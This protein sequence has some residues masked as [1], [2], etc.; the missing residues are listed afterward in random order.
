MVNFINTAPVYLP[1]LE[2]GGHPGWEVVEGTPTELNDLLRSGSL[3]AGL[4]S[5]F[6]YGVDHDDYV[7]L[8]DLGISACG[9]VGSVLL[10]SRMEIDTLDGHVVGLTPQ[11]ATSVNLLRIIFEKF[12]GVRPRYRSGCFMELEQGDA[13][14]YLSIGDEA[15]RR[16]A[17]ASGY[18][19]YDLASIWLEHTGLPFVFAVCAVRDDV[20]RGNPDGVR[21]LGRKLSEC[22]YRGRDE[23]ERIS[24][25]VAPRIP[26]TP[27]ECLEYLTGIDFD[28]SC[29]KQEGLL[30]FFRELESLGGFPRIDRLDMIN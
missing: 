11:S 18:H 9:A 2:S 30:T 14:A 15:L 6:A 21:S 13:A 28:L 19:V 17:A 29:R 24:R 12:L 16:R 26:M 1:W 20:W 7:L 4:V 3:D 23:L 25:M 10:F 22:R 5:S 27:G 8:P